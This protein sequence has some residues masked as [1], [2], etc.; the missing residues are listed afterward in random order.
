MKKR[1]LKDTEHDKIARSVRLNLSRIETVTEMRFT[2][3]A[4]Y[5]G[6]KHTWRAIYFT[7][8]VLVGHQSSFLSISIVFVHDVLSSVLPYSQ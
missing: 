6:V 4:A 1:T 5:H 8:P 2:V 3:L 7:Y